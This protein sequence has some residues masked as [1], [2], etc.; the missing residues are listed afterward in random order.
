M[1]NVVVLVLFMVLFTAGAVSLPAP[2]LAQEAQTGWTGEAELGIVTTGGN[3]KT[4]SVSAKLNVGN[5]RH[6]WRHTVT[7]EML[8]TS[9]A[10]QTTA[11][12]Y[13]A[14]AKSDFK[15]TE[16]NYLFL[17]GEFEKDRFSGFKQRTNETIGYGR[18]VIH[19]ETVRL[20]M[21]I[22]QGARQSEEEGTGDHTDECMTRGAANLTWDIRGHTRF[23]EEVTVDAGRDST[24]T[25]SVTSLKNQIAGHLASKITFT[26]RNTSEVPPGLK[27]SDRETAVTLV[28]S[29]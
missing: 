17:R 26:V 18:R 1:R 11:E 22:G 8:N 28:Y 4:E 7:G 16:N 15:F 21:E 23:S 19:T 13:L 29:F 9:D 20:D 6:R 3:T 10:G 14:S 24:I 12:R 5:E 27:H 25:R 2:A